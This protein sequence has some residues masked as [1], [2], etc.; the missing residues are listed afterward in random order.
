MTATSKGKLRCRPGATPEF[1]KAWAELV[2]TLGDMGIVIEADR[3]AMESLVFWQLTFRDAA[4]HLDAEGSV[5]PSKRGGPRLSPWVRISE[6]ASANVLKLLKQFGMTPASRAALKLPTPHTP[7][8][9]DL[10]RLAHGDGRTPF[11]NS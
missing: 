9:I 4:R 3:A 5:I 1:R 6:T 7:D 2:K 11:P 10:L 8:M